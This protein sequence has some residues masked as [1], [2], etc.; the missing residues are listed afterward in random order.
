MGLVLAKG[1]LNVQFVVM[2][3]VSKSVLSESVVWQA[4]SDVLLCVFVSF[5]SVKCIVLLLF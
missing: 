2:I 5:T 1:L 3:I 4:V